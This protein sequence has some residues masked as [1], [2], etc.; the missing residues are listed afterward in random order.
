MKCGNC[1]KEMICTV[2]ICVAEVGNNF[3]FVD[4]HANT[5][6]ID[7]KIFCTFMCAEDYVNNKYGIKVKR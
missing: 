1:N 7:G 5:K 3:R 2:N 6:V 4:S